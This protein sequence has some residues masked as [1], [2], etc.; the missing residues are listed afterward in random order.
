MPQ[1]L[2]PGKGLPL[3]TVQPRRR[4]IPECQYGQRAGVHLQ[5]PDRESSNEDYK[6]IVQVL[7]NNDV[8]L[9]FRWERTRFFLFRSHCLR[10]HVI[11]CFVQAELCCGR[12]PLF[13]YCGESIYFSSLP[14]KTSHAQLLFPR[15]VKLG[16]HLMTFFL[17]VFL[18]RSRMAKLTRRVRGTLIFI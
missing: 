10:C 18:A 12:L 6:D 11:S 17:S 4:R 16:R 2:P 15:V 7:Q 9:V 8:Y 14:T 13:H 1:V 3:C 5:I